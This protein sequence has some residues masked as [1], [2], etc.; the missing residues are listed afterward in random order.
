VAAERADAGRAAGVGLGVRVGRAVVALFE[1][2]DQAVT[3]RLL[4]GARAVRHRLATRPAPLDRA[5]G[6]AAVA[7]DQVAVVA[8]LARAA[9]P[10]AAAHAVAIV[11]DRPRGAGLA[12][13][14][15]RH[16]DLIDAHLVHPAPVRARDALVHVRAEHARPLVARIALAGVRAE[17][18]HAGRVLVAVVEPA[19]ALVDVGAVEAVALEAVV[20]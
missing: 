9:K 12:L 5:G 10:V 3:A 13:A 18:V 19:R 14:P 20:A 11:P 7:V 16:A 6:A 4:A 1:R 8:R 17:G 15:V 2:V